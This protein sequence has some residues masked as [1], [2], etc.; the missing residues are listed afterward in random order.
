MWFYFGLLKIKLKHYPGL[1]IF[2]WNQRVDFHIIS[3]VALKVATI[4]V[5]WNENYSLE[6]NI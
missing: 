2:Y 3:W 4:E 1:S 6:Q 5:Q